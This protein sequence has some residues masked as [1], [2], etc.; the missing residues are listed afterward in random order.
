MGLQESSSRLY[1]SHGTDKY[2]VG[3]VV[4]KTKNDGGE[5]QQQFTQPSDLYLRLTLSKGPNE[6]GVFHPPHLR[7]DTDPVSEKLWFVD[8]RI[9]DDGRSPKPQEFWADC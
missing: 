6:V 3:P 1:L 9:P 5:A 7:T 4:P 2:F 8:S